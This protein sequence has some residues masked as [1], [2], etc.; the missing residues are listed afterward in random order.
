MPTGHRC[1]QQLLLKAVMTA[2]A[3]RETTAWA[4]GTAVNHVYL[5]EG[6]SFLAYIRAGTQEP[7]W[8]RKPI[9]FSRSGRRFTAV[10]P[11]PFGSSMSVLTPV[12]TREVAGSGGKTY[13]INLDEGS[14]TCQ[15]YTFRGVCKHVKELA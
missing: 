15:G 1:S 2:Q 6:D 14:C 5:I 11:D 10:N 4:E 8:F 3:F 12:N 13:I 7:F 9:K